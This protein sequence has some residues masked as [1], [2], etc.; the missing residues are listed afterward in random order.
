[1]KLTINIPVGPGSPAAAPSA[2]P[3][4]QAGM[5]PTCLHEHMRGSGRVIRR[6]RDQE[7]VYVLVHG[8]CRHCFDR[9]SLM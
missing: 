3:A 9:V 8:V 1:M 5:G 7:G 2:P 6:G 4:V